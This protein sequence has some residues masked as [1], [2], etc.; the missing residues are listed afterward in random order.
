MT[1]SNQ[2]AD[3]AVAI[4]DAGPMI[5]ATVRLPGCSPERALAAF[6][7]PALLAR[8]WRG[9]LTTELRPG[10]RYR[11]AFPGIPAELAGRV[12]SYVPGSMLRFRWEWAGE[13]GR[14]HSTVTVSVQPACAPDG[15]LLTIEH[16][17]HADDDAGRTA[18]AEHW[19]GWE[20]FLPRL[21]A[22]VAQSAP[23]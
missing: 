5:V 3:S 4:A 15:T 7:D 17:P 16:G 23:E 22:A 1:D 20:F 10:G 6:T 21:P 9:E 19:A 14:P 8:W 18:H 13:E 11:V 12:V 2:S